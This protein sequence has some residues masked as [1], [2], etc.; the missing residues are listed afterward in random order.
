MFGY[1]FWVDKP[2]WLLLLLLLIPTFL[3]ALRSIGG[4]SRGKTV[5]T[6]ALRSL[7]II[8][9]VMALAEPNWAKRGEGLTAILLIDRSDSIPYALKQ[10]SVEFLRKAAAAKEKPDDS[11]GVIEIARDAAITAMPDPY[12]AVP[13][14]RDENDGTATNLA[15]GVRMGLATAREDTAN[16]FVFATDGNE[17]VDSVLAAAQLAQANKIPID[18]LMLEYEHDREVIFEDLVADPR[19]R[20][21]QPITVKMVLRSRGPATGK[22][23]LAIN[24][25]MVDL[26]GEAAGVALPVELIGGPPLVIPVTLT[27]DSPGPQ[28]FE[29]KFEPDDPSQDL[30]AQNNEQVA[31]TFVGSS[32]RVL[33]IDDSAAQSAHL[34]AALK[35]SDI[36][37]KRVDPAGVGSLIDL[38]AYD[39]VVL[40]NV[41]R[42]VFPDEVDRALH[43]YVH[44][45]GGG[46]VMLG[47]PSSFGAGGWIDSDVAKALPVKLDPPSMQQ[48][49]RGALCIIMHSCEMPQ[50]NFWGEQMAIA[51]I[52]ALSGQDFIGIIDFD[53]GAG[54]S[55]W[56]F[57]LGLA[58][59][60]AAAIAAAKKMTNGDMPDFGSSMQMALNGLTAPDIRAGKKHMIIITDGDPAPPSDALLQK[61]IDAK[62][63]ITTVMVAGHG[64]RQDERNLRIIADNTGG[65]YYNVTNPKSLP[66]IF[67]K[68][69]QI[70]SRSLIVDGSTYQPSVVSR[71]PGPV[72]GFA[73]VPPIDG[74]VLTAMRDGLAQ[75]PIVSV[76]ELSGQMISDPIFANWNY[77][78]GKSLAYTSDLTGLWGAHWIAW[79]EFR[80]FWEKAIRWV[81][82]PSS[83]VNF[84]IKT[85]QEGS[86]AFVE[87]EALEGDASFLSNLQTNA[88]VLGPDGEPQPLSLQQIGPGRYRGEFRTSEAGAYLVNISY[89]GG[90]GRS[91]SGGGG[92]GKPAIRGNVQAA[93]TVPFS[94]EF[95]AVKHNRALM[96][97]LV[98]RTKGRMLELDDSEL[99]N[100]FDRTNLEVP[101][102]PKR[103][104]DLLAILAAALF[105]L[106]VAARRL[107]IDPAAIAAMVRRAL[108]QR[109]ETG[110]DTMEAWRKARAQVAHRRTEP[111]PTAEAPIDRAAKFEADDAARAAAIDVGG[112]GPEATVDPA[113]AKQRRDEPKAAP[114][115]SEDYT[116]RLLK[117]KRRARGGDEGGSKPPTPFGGG[118]GD[119]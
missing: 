58:R 22:V 62:I 93:V 47:G 38:S 118:G 31:V 95:R 111:M 33:V 69:A 114:V 94:A 113:A 72:E 106:D 15:A 41:P 90:A 65:T 4:L 57:P 71:L 51:A 49:P 67:I 12:S 91:A 66:Q 68:E 23:T 24:G 30:I 14:P 87:V 26:N 100:L 102:S 99:V 56:A 18:V 6:F 73:S 98:D 96:Q 50:G 39:A 110:K 115:E 105:V 116:S 75:T 60:K 104:W 79:P 63:S 81:M 37:V 70:V 5:V 27:L 17:T 40:A 78:L 117:A 46:L 88:V 34:I 1:E 55:N 42:Y 76:G 35:N 64:S 59:D 28:R 10:R 48:L 19:A 8:L 107:A 11:I 7:V 92:A 3:L 83:P 84:T 2:R 54:G 32:G 112:E 109:T 101:R 45:L 53:W 16:R 25:D 119:A 80:A 77:G 9:L 85:R 44:D 21:G 61:F 103:I 86:S 97:E 89:A 13:T 29:A 82:R 36:E 108:G 52:E 74:Y 43:A 20:F